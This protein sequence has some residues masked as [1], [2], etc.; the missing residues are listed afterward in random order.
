MYK[1]CC[2]IPHRKSAA[3]VWTLQ[4]QKKERK[5]EK[6]KTLKK[7]PTS[8]KKVV[9]SSDSR[10]ANR[11][12]RK[13]TLSSHSPPPTAIAY[14]RG[15]RKVRKFLLNLNIKRW[16]SAFNA[17]GWRIIIII[18]TLLKLGLCST[19]ASHTLLSIMP[20]A[21]HFNPKHNALQKKS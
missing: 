11:L 5:K 8:N 10:K 2:A 19:L 4:P 17:Q 18:V 9:F 14:L 15:I 16:N 3:C 12:I 6:H 21:S 13:V 1:K 7:A 20:L